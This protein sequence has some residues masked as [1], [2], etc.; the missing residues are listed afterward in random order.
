VARHRA[1]RAQARTR[2]RYPQ[3]QAGL[4]SLQNAMRRLGSRALDSRTTLA[5]DMRWFRD[6]LLTDVAGPDPTTSQTAA[7]T[8]LAATKLLLEAHDAFLLTALSKAPGAVGDERLQ[9]L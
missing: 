4:M 6:S 9:T 2:T 1:R 7:A 5:R 3:T 8:A